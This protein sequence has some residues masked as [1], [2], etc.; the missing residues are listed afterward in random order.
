MEDLKVFTKNIEETAL[1]QIETL[2]QQEAFKNSKIRIMP[3]VHA[4]KGCVIGFTGDLGDKIVPNIVGVDIGCGM[5]TVDLGKGNID[6]KR[7]D[8]I[9]EN[10]IPSG[11]NS[12]AEESTKF[13]LTRLRCYDELINKEHI[14]SSMGTLGGGNHF[15]EIDEDE[16]DNKYLIIHTGSRNLGKQVA[17]IYQRKAIKYCNKNTENKQQI[18]KKL[19]EQGRESE[20]EKELKN[21]EIINIPKE[22]C[23]LEGSEAEEYLHDMKIAMEFATQNRER[24]ADII[25][26]N[27]GMDIEHSF[28]TMHNY[29][30][31]DNIVRKGSISAY[32]DELVLIPINMRDG[33]IIAR[34]KG[35]K[36]W[37]YSA[38][39]GAGRIMSRK[40]AKE[41]INI[42]DFKATMQD[43]H[44][45]ISDATIDEAPFAYKD[46]QEIIENIGDTVDIIKIIKPIYN[47]KGGQ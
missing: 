25:T 32:K 24:I 11:F 18:I 6:F 27:L 23:Y 39:H 43:I 34:G 16:E 33:C 15:I 40:Q 42:E 17:D 1:E 38:P 47:F 30:G 2:L 36:D 13:D 21:I 9:I 45:N 29:I 44:A 28:E 46:I 8:R 41:T 35:N 5:L 20:I 22:L 4:G 3:D 37:N 31:E 14:L 12:H 7:V 10:Y 26:E 19:K